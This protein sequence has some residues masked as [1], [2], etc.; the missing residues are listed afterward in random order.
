MPRDF[1]VGRLDSERVLRA[2]AGNG[3]RALG[4][5]GKLGSLEAG[6]Y[7]DLL[8]VGKERIF[9]PPG[10]YDGEPFLDVVLD[11]AE[12]ADIDTVM[13]HGRI[14]MENGTVT[15]VDEALV[16]ERFAR[17]MSQRVYHPSAE[18][19]RWAELGTLVEPYLAGFYR[20]W[21]E[22]PVEPAHIYNVRRPPASPGHPPAP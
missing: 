18:V 10:R 11:R 7:A 1:E 17:A 19:R 15:V 20:P 6:R 16:R 22:T 21:Y 5:E 2:A 3:A 9:F 12:S 4:M 14:L 13:A 8:I